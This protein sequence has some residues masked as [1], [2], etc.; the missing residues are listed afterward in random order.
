MDDDYIGITE[1]HAMSYHIQ[2]W[3]FAASGKL[4]L[5]AH[6]QNFWNAYKP[7]SYRLHCINNGEIGMPRYLS[8]YGIHPNPL[9]TQ[10]MILDLIFEGT[11]AEAVETL[12]NY[13]GPQEFKGLFETV[14]RI[15][16]TQFPDERT[17]HGFLKRGVMERLG[18]SNTMNAANLILLNRTAFPFVKKDLVYRGRYLFTQI[19][20]ALG[21]WVG[22][23]A[24]QLKEI[25]SYFRSRG[26]LWWQYSPSAI[27]ARMGLL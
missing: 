23:D 13:I 11:L 12:L 3:F 6:F 25:L 18:K 19:D 2:S 16:F 27:F 15:T 1:T 5:N 17:A 7:L 8:R 24:E 20:R 4:F 9:Y 22:E 26:T 10:N 21:E 14:E